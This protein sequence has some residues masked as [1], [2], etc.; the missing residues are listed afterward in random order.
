MQN[1]YEENK[2]EREDKKELIDILSKQTQETIEVCTTRIATTMIEVM[3]NTN[4]KPSTD[5]DIIEAKN[6]ISYIWNNREG[7]A[8]CNTGT[9]FVI[10]NCTIHIALN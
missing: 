1:L 2:T 4:N 7:Y 9:S 3:Q 5:T 6:N 8:N 10:R